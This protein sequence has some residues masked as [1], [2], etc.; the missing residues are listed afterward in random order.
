MQFIINCV[1]GRKPGI[2]DEDCYFVSAVLLPLLKKQGKLHI[3]F[4]V[5][6]EN[7]KIQPGEI[8]FPGGRVETKELSNP[9]ET[10]VRETMEEL[11]I[12]REDIRVIGPLDILPTPQGR[13]V[14][15]YV[16]EILTGNLN[17]NPEEV[18]E[19]F[20]V[21]VDFFL[22]N[23]PGISSA[24]VA[25]RYSSGFPFHRIPPGYRHEWQKRWS[26]PTYYFEYGQYFIWGLT[27]KILHHFLKLCWPERFNYY[28]KRLP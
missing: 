6:A 27:A 21:P 26:F 23:P 5:R 18:A 8:C 13:L 12:K 10:A 7:L 11:G 22:N 14:Y 15:P 9:Q 24:D 1:A 16:G 19:I 25:I 3:L 28:P 4:E 17:P 2:M 20:T